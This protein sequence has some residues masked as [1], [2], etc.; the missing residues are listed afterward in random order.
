MKNIRTL[1]LIHSII[2]CAVCT[3]A[4]FYSIAEGAGT[5]SVNDPSKTLL[6]VVQTYKTTDNDTLLD[7]ARLFGIGYNA[8][9][10]ANPAVDPWVPAEGIAITI[11][12]QWIVPELLDDGILINLAEMR[13]YSF[14]SSNGHKFVKAYPIGIGREGFNSPEGLFRITGKIENPAWRPTKRMRDENPD[15]DPIIPPGEDNPL[16][17]YWLQLS[18]PSYGIHGTNKPYSVGR[19]ISSGCIRLYPEDIEELYSYAKVKTT[20]KIINE[21]VKATRYN[22]MV[23]IEV[24]ANGFNIEELAAKALKQL[25]GKDLLKFVDPKLLKSAIDDATGLPTIISR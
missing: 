18:I 12:T 20:V 6:G 9:T 14:F 16:G 7:V 3:G 19:R 15:L 2:V 13:L 22:D 4:F 1:S 11:P 23:Y 10:E 8:I 21:P 25:S 17:D 24:H 5:Y